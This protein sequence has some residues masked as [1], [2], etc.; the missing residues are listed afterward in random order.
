M[1]RFIELLR[2]HRQAFEQYY[3]HKLSS[4]KR[5]AIFAMLSCQH[6]PLRASR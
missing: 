5:R 3:G 4:D 2:Q 1:N 6:S